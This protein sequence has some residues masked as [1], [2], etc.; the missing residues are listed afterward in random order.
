MDPV[1]SIITQRFDPASWTKTATI[2]P[3]TNHADGVT[4]PDLRQTVYERDLDGVTVSAG[5]FWFKDHPIFIAW[6]DKAATHCGFNAF[7]DD[8]LGLGTIQVGCPDV[9]ANV[10]DGRVLGFTLNMPDQTREFT[11]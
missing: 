6:G 4:I 8:N 2:E 10:K 9:V 5:V 1:A 11:V 3:F 7:L